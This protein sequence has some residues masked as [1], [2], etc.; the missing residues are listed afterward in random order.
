MKNH[1]WGK[2]GRKQKTSRKLSTLTMFERKLVLFSKTPLLFL[3]SM[4]PGEWSPPRMLWL[5][6]ISRYHNLYFY[7][8]CIHLLFKG[9]FPQKKK[10][11]KRVRRFVVPMEHSPSVFNVSLQEIFWEIWGWITVCAVGKAWACRRRIAFSNFILSGASVLEDA[12]LLTWV[13]Q[14]WPP[15]TL[16]YSDSD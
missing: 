11:K 5:R 10:K 16:E 7:P 9:I 2:R 15:N 6:K 14:V 4:V 8:H 1:I 12:R 13:N 3:F